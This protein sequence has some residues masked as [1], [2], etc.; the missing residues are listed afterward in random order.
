[1]NTPAKAPESPDPQTP[2]WF[3]PDGQSYETWRDERL[4]KDARNGNDRWKAE[5]RSDAYDYRIIRARYNELVSL[6]RSGDVRSLM[7]YYDE[8]VHGNTG[9]MGSPRLYPKDMFG[10]KV[11]INDYTEQMV[12]GLEQIFQAPPEALS[13]DEKLAFF[14]RSAQA[15]GE[16]ALML[17]GA[18][19]LGPFHLGVAR[20][21]WLQGVLPTIISGASAGSFVAAVLCTHSDAE[22]TDLFVRNELPRALSVLTEPAAGDR[23]GADQLWHMIEQLVPDMTFGEALARSGRHL[24]ISVAPAKLHQQSRTLN[25]VTSPNVMIR[26]AIMASCAIPGIFDPVMLFARDAHG[27]RVPYVRSRTWVDGSVTDDQPTNRLSRVYGANF[28]ITSQTNPVVLWAVQDPHS[29]NPFSRLASMY[30][31]AAKQW[32][33]FTYPYAMSAVRGVYPLNVMT[34]MWFSVLTQDYTADVNIIPKRRFPNPMKLLSTLSD[35]ETRDLVR[36]GERSTWPHIERIRIST[37]FGR[38][39]KELLAALE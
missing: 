15:Y 22:L 35:D 4:R 13:T 11:L 2:V 18:G 38:K 21:L 23:I 19:S 8:G 24:N 37:R 33:E 36:D 1:M 16:C 25:P 29:R 7:F 34:R 20:A 26:E 9:G 27:E 10:T 31:S 6:R 5:D 17:S 14:R 12:Q 32:T 3:D 39:L 30:Q 28:F